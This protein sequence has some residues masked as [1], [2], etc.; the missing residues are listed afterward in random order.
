MET[1][2]LQNFYLGFEK[3]YCQKWVVFCLKCGHAYVCA[4]TYMCVSVCVHEM[5]VGCVHLCEG[6]HLYVCMGVCVPMCK[7]RHF[8]QSL[9]IFSDKVSH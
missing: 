8:P 9:S 7:V 5:N 4:H 2:W 1:R 3:P 6:V